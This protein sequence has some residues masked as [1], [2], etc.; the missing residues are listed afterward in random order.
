MYSVVVPDLLLKIAYLSF[1]SLLTSSSTLQALHTCCAQL[2]WLP[3]HHCQEIKQLW[4]IWD[5]E[6]LIWE[7][8]FI[9]WINCYVFVIWSRYPV[10]TTCK[11]IW[12]SRG[13]LTWLW[14]N[15]FSGYFKWIL[16]VLVCNHWP[17]CHVIIIFLSNIYLLI[18]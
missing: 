4:C 6:P 18:S 3:S 10:R 5:C 17:P 7:T 16:C 12:Q 8:V 13:G 14:L 15:P 11:V 1:L 2:W 9:S